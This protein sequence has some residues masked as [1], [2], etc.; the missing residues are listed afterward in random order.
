MYQ[1]E[2]DKRIEKMH[3]EN[4]QS[5]NKRDSGA[6][7]GGFMH[8]VV[9]LITSYMSKEELATEEIRKREIKKNLDMM[10]EISDEIKGIGKKYCTA[11]DL[12]SMVKDKDRKY[13]SESLAKQDQA[14]EIGR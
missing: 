12:L 1:T 14:E 4:I 13:A 5:F 7:F 3:E 9:A 8:D 10:Y 6:Q 11:E 2:K